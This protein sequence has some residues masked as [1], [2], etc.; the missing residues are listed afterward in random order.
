MSFYKFS[1]KSHVIAKENTA[2]IFSPS[3]DSSK[4][5]YPTAKGSTYLLFN[6]LVFSV[7]VGP[8][9]IFLFYIIT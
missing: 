7:N 4:A 3:V 1:V 2:P 6:F 8:F 9:D 5:I